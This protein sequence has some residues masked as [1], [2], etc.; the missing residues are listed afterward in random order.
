MPGGRRRS[1]RCRRTFA[2]EDFLRRDGTDAGNLLK[3]LGRGGMQ[4]DGLQRRFLLSQTP[5]VAQS[6]RT[7]KRKPTHRAG[8]LRHPVMTSSYITI[9]Y[10]QK[11]H[12]DRG[13]LGWPS[14]QG[15]SL[16]VVNLDFAEQRSLSFNLRAV[17][18]NHNL[19]VGGIEIFPRRGQ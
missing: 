17:A 1:G 14:V 3:F 4:V 15:F 18:D 7:V 6:T 2:L 8:T 11:Q 9:I 19:H 16:R 5:R 13:R 10:L 12:L